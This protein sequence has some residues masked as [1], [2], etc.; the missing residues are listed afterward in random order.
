MS[1]EITNKYRRNYRNI[2]YDCKYIDGFESE[3]DW[4]VQM[5][6]ASV[7]NMLEAF[8]NLTLETARKHNPNKNRSK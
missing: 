1:I 8:Y 3:I 7:D 4:D 5:A 2:N 6:N